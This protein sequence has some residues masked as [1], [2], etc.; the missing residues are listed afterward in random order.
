MKI[1][2]STQLLELQQQAT[3]QGKQCPLICIDRG[4][5]ASETTEEDWEDDLPYLPSAIV[6]TVDFTTNLHRSC[7]IENL[8]PEYGPHCSKV[9]VPAS[10]PISMG[11]SEEQ[12]RRILNDSSHIVSK[13]RFPKDQLLH[14]IPTEEDK[15]N[16]SIIK[17]GIIASVRPH[18][19]RPNKKVSEKKKKLRIHF[20]KDLEVEK[21]T[22][23]K[24]QRTHK[25]T[26]SPSVMSGHKRDT[27]L[28]LVINPYLKTLNEPEVAQ[29]DPNVYI[30]QSIMIE[31]VSQVSSDL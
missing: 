19:S 22:S 25:N 10:P 12:T 14:R 29:K 15:S 2:S 6:V 30:P 11:L 18:H 20:S 3:D 16:K 21:P 9:Y 5:L 26:E 31:T 28:K 13:C 4:V 27:G 17:E 1:L 7:F 24:K 23:R 8:V